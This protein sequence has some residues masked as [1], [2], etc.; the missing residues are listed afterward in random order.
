MEML[1]VLSTIVILVLATGIWMRKRSVTWHWRLMIAAF[2]LDIGLVLYIEIT[3]HAIET[4]A[5]E[6]SP[7]IWFHAAVSTAVLVLYFV[8]FALG[9]KI[10]V[11]GNRF[12][13]T[14][15]NVAL[16]FCACRG[17]N[18]VTSYWV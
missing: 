14:H 18:Y 2:I 1:H 13:L 12:R 3:R 9:R 16:A 10:I 8:M 11:S 15:R 7:L 6:I 4:V 17:I 5:G